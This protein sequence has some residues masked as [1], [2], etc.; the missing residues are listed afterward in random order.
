MGKDAELSLIA[1]LKLPFE[2]SQKERVKPHAA[3]SVL[4]AVLNSQAGRMFRRQLWGSKTGIVI[5]IVIKANRT[6][7]VT[8]K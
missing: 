3:H 1:S 5:I 4:C 6:E 8:L 2:I 7:A